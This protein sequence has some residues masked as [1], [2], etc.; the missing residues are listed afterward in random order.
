MRDSSLD[1]Q[2]ENFANDLSSAKFQR[3]SFGLVLTNVNSE[4]AGMNSKTR[5]VVSV[6]TVTVMT[7][8][9]TVVSTMSAVTVMAAVSAV[10]IV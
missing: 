4:A 9:S 3:D 2:K 8:V 10:I 1:A 6:S 7:A 5:S